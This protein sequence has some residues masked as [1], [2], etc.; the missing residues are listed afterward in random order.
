MIIVFIFGIST[1]LTYSYY[2][3]KCFG[4][5][6]KVKYGPLYN[7]FYVIT[8]ILSSVVTVELVISLIDLSFA[9]MTIPNMI[10]IIY[11]SK[12]VTKEMKERSWI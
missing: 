2:G 12:V 10:A 11:L 4:Y 3:V 8:I 6:T 7:Y 9:L 5:L 1:L